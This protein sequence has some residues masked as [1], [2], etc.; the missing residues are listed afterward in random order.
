MNILFLIDSIRRGGRERRMIELLKGLKIHDSIHVDV[1][2]FSDIIAYEE[3]YNLNYPIHKFDRKVKKDPT[4]FFRLHKL[5]NDLA[6]DVIHSWGTMSTIF[7]I[8]SSKILRIPLINGNIAD[9]PKNMGFFDARL[10]RAQLTFPFS[11]IIVGNS[12][13]GLR[14]YHAPASKSHCVYNGFDV[15]R[16]V[17]LARPESVKQRMHIEDELVVGMVGGFYDRKDYKTYLQ[18]AIQIALEHPDVTFLAIGD[19]PN[20]A[21]MRAMIPDQLKH[22]IRL[23]GQLNDVEPVINSFDIGVLATNAEIHGEGISNAILEYMALAKPTIAT[24]GGGTPEIVD[25]GVTGF[26]VPPQDLSAMVEKM[27]ALINN[28]NLRIDMGKTAR[29]YVMEKFSLDVMKQKY[30]TL[31]QTCLTVKKTSEP[32]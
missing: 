16:F 8:P 20:L 1:G 28:K 24:D 29:G 23:P 5:I 18:A 10:F 30:L 7:A 21:A 4:L 31:Y 9:A 19:G 2:V 12:E 32:S 11:D 22:R 25:D 6:P 15:A 14:A 26:L 3:I 13:A 27:M 17:N